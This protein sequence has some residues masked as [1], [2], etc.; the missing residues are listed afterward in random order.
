MK[1]VNDKWVEWVDYKFMIDLL[2]DLLQVYDCK[3]TIRNIS[4]YLW[5]E[6]ACLTA[7]WYV[8]CLP[9]CVFV[10][11][12]V[13]VCS[14]VSVCLYSYVSMCLYVCQSLCLFVGLSVGCLS[15]GRSVCFSFS[16]SVCLHLF[17]C[18]FACLCLSM[19]VCLS[20]CPLS[21]GP[22]SVFLSC[23][24]VTVRTKRASSGEEDAKSERTEGYAHKSNRLRTQEW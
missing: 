4:S 16:Q 10:C 22:S 3:V 19:S 18:L 17:V 11:L 8:S 1:Y 12:S 15:S 24:S 20:R 7:G 2:S 9:M 13:D 5:S 23:H 21:V 6:F 14:S